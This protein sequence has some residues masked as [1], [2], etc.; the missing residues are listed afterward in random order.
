MRVIKYDDIVKSIRDMIIYS[1]THLSPDMKKALEEAY[2]NE[3]S[4]VSRAVLAQLLENAVIAEKEWKPLCQDTGLAIYFVKVGE[5]LRW[6]V[7]A[8]KMQYMRELKKV[9]KKGI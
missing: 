7:E 1:T 6:K 8:L 2:E 3:K 5:M 4:E 9:I